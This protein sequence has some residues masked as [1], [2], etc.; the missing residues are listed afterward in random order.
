[1]KGWNENLALTWTNNVPPSRP[2]NYEMCVYT[3]YL[4]IL[5]KKTTKKIK[6]LV[7]GSTPEFRDWGYEQN[8]SITVID[9]SEDYHKVISRE[10]RHKNIMEKVIFDSW[11]TMKLDEQY[12]I[13]IGDLAIGNIAPSSF[14]DFIKTISQA[15]KVGGFFIGKSFF[16]EPTDDIKSPKQ[17][18]NEYYSFS[19]IHPYTFINHQLGLYCLDKKSFTIDF[20]KMHKELIKLLD[21]KILNSNTFEYFKN[22]GWDTDMKFL[23][24]APTR[25]YFVQQINKKM[26]FL[27][28]IE[29]NEV[30]TKQFPIYIVTKEEN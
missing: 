3:D 16:W 29:T 2:S 23:F 6:M 24:Y 8:L 27:E 21:Q 14:E 17:I 28:F 9:K 13:I 19:Q 30:Y 5:R 18:I 22:V 10:L 11:E 4:N 12:D 15:L 7:L 26:K 1:M 25:S 20:S